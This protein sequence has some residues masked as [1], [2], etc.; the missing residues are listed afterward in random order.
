MYD[1]RWRRR[2]FVPV[3]LLTD[4]AWD[5]L[6]WVFIET[7]HGRR[8]TST[9]AA[10]AAGVTG[11]IGLRWISALRKAGLVMPWWAD[12]DTDAHVRLSD[13]GYRGMQHYLSADA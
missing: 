3:E 2:A 5:I 1:D 12:D 8:V 7:E 10:V 4:P 13:A 11:D 9:E 6:L